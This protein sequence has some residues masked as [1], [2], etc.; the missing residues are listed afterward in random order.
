MAGLGSVCSHI[1]ALLFK[2]VACAQ[3]GLNK[4]SCT[5]TFCSWK[6]SRKS[7]T[8]APLK[9]INFSRPK[10][11]KTLPNI[12]DNEN[13]QDERPY[14]FKDPTPTSDSKKKKLLELKKLYKNAAVLQSVDIKNESK[15][16][17]S[18]TDTAEEDDSYN[19]YNLPE[20]LTSLYLPASINL[21]DSTL[22]KYCAKSYEEYKITQ[23]VNMYSNLL[24]V[25]NIQSASRIWKLHRAGRITAS[26]SKTAYNI[27]VDKYPKSFI[28]TVMQYNAEFITK[29]TSY[30]KKMETV[31]I[32]SYKQ[33]VAKTHTNIVVTE[34]GLHVLHKN[35]CLGASP[36]S[37]VCCDCHGSGVV[38]IK[39]PYKYRNGLENWKT[40]TDFPVNFDNTVKKTHQYYFQVQQEMYIT[41]TTY[42]HFYIWTE[43]K[44]ENDTMLINVPIDRVFCEKLETKL[45][46]IFF[47]FLLPEIVS[48][49]NDPNNLLSDQTY[50]ICK[51]PSFTPMIGCDGKNCKIG[52]FHYSCIEIK[53]GPK[54]KWFCKECI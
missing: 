48:R 31:A 26:L 16:H 40:D 27:K 35:P 41:N 39:C 34:T 12:S 52:W 17:C 30:G 28:N 11:R 29:P 42:C 49:K 25:T 54:G 22:T 21:D 6:K 18:D 1:G 45:T 23:S 32:N 50:C 38:E 33:F 4:I 36:D 9:K 51:R 8:P 19:E 3:L 10:K 13:S 44:N 20:P 15:E 5:S 2:L 53:N 7:A 43:G 46:T 47:K 37:M 14:S 24:K